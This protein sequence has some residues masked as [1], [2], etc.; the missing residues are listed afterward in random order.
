MPEWKCYAKPA[1]L[2][3]E[4]CGHL[5]KEGIMYC[6]LLCCEKCGCT[7]FASDDRRKK[8]IEGANEVVSEMQGA[9][10]KGE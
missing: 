2:G 7:K 4:T 8:V 9:E 5:N 1:R 10:G 3:G 6:G